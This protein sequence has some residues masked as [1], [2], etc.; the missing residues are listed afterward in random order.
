MKKNCNIIKDL[1]PLYVDDICSEESKI[2]IEDHLKKCPNCKKYLKDIETEIKETP[3]ITINT[4]KNFSKK[5]NF[6]ILINVIIYTFLILFIYGLIC[7]L[8]NQNI[9][10]MNSDA[11]TRFIINDYPNSNWNFQFNVPMDGKLST[12]LVKVKENGTNVN[13]VFLNHKYSINGM[14]EA[15]K[16]N[17]KSLAPC[18]LT[19]ELNYKIINLNEKI[20]V[21]YINKDLD[22]ID[23]SN[24]IYK[25]IDEAKI[26]FTNEKIEKT[27][28]CTLDNNYYKYNLEYYKVN[29]QIIKENFKEDEMPEEI[30]CEGY[31]INGTYKTLLSVD[32]TE[33]F[34]KLND[35]VTSQG[36]TCSFR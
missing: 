4:F 13:I 7:T 23:W 11:N 31:D 22:K 36:G 30:L 21:Y 26:L 28:E 12:K 17:K 6:K 35:Y 33:A 2:L 34:T 9:F 15:Y 16:N 1:L 29:K 20:R 14:L 3:H 25:I 10:I 27:M 5:I 8:C 32:A 24:D 19:P 18:G